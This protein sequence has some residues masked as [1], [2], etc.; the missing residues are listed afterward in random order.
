MLAFPTHGFSQPTG[1]PPEVTHNVE[2]DILCDWIE[3]SVL[4]DQEDISTTD[5]VDV[6]I[7]EDVYENRD[8]A[9]NIVSR[10][11][12]ELKRRLKWIGSGSP[13]LFS[14]RKIQSLHSWQENP[15]YSFCVL[16]SMSKCYDYWSTKLGASGYAKQGQLFES[17]T[18]ASMENQF[19]DWEIYQTG[20]SAT[21]PVKLSDVVNEVANRLGEEEGNIKPWENPDGNDAG[22]DLLCY[23]P[24]PDNRVG[25]PVYLVQCASGKN[26]FHKLNEPDLK[27]WKKMILFVATP[28]KA[29]AI[30]FAL[31]DEEFR[32]KCNRVDGML[33]DRYRLLAAAN[34]NGTWISDSLGQEI[35]DWVTPRLDTL[36]RYNE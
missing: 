16:L 14:R 31:L 17:L 21:N 10:A 13:F 6:L 22:L 12:N 5:V 2:L 20:W 8:L 32:E 33:L 34:Y 9:S 29:F 19:S 25:V 27:V 3:G 4:F 26:W 28:K 11:W 36:R 18:K 15:A 7:R 23:R 1:I 35:I 24:F 30:P